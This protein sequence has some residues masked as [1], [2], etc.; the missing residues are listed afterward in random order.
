M[1][2][3]ERVGSYVK[4]QIRGGSFALKFNTVGASL[5]KSTNVKLHYNYYIPLVNKFTKGRL[6]GGSFCPLAKKERLRRAVTLDEYENIYI[7]NTLS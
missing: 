5:L 2:E 1:G 6:S 4:K 7:N 3:W